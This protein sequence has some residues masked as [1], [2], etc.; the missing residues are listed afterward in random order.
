MTDGRAKAHERYHVAMVEVKRRLR[1]VNRILGAKKSR[2]LTLDTDNEFSWLQVRKVIELVAFAGISSDEAR[3]AALRMEAKDNPDYTR[4]WKVGDILKR[5]SKITPHFLPIPIGSVQVMGDGLWHFN[6]GKEKQTLER[7][8][9]IYERAGE[10]LHVPNPFGEVS[11]EQHQQLVTSSR[12][13]LYKDVLYLTSVL[14]THAKV[15]LEFDPK[16][17]EPRGAANPISAWLVQ[18]GKP[19]TDEVRVVLAEGIDRPEGRADKE[20]VPSDECISAAFDGALAERV[21]RRQPDRLRTRVE[22]FVG[23]HPR[24]GQGGLPALGRA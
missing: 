3:Y 12:K 19:E 4:D 20:D 10:H 8:V 21:Q 5:L 7:F 22:G 16:D 18:L 13:Q 15:G 11:L 23:V 17:D 1:A 2:T 24:A 14:W 9:E 6:E